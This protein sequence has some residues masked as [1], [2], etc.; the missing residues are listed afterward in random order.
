[1]ALLLGLLDE[2]VTVIEASIVRLSSPFVEATSSRG[3]SL[4]S[5]DLTTSLE[6]L[7]TAFHVSLVLETHVPFYVFTESIVADTESALVGKGSRDLTL[8]LVFSS[9]DNACIVDQTILRGVLLGLEGT[10]ES[11]L[12]TKDLDG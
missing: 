10:E 1:M 4:L 2:I 6:K 5:D 3:T 8:E 7:C 12:S 9:T 11:L